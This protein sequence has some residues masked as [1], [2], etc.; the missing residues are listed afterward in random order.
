MLLEEKI[1]KWREKLQMENQNPNHALVLIMFFS[2]NF[3]CLNWN[4]SFCA[5]IPQYKPAYWIA[6]DNF[7]I[8]ALFHVAL[9]LLNS[10]S[11]YLLTIKISNN[12]HY[13]IFPIVIPLKGIIW[14]IPW[15]EGEIRKQENF[16][17][18]RI[19]YWETTF[20]SYRLTQ[21]QETRDRDMRCWK[22]NI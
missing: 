6:W 3:C 8:T 4:D 2:L 15:K 1:K 13:S 7:E 16:H 18:F 14:I 5:G 11:L 22:C 12:F 17:V 21:E 19:T 20:L 9:L 10:F